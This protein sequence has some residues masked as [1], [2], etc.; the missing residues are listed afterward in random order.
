MSAPQDILRDRP[1]AA[2]ISPFDRL[3]HVR[4]VCCP[5]QSFERD[6]D[7]DVADIGSAGGVEYTIGHCKAC[8][9]L[10]VHCWV[11]GGISE[12]LEAVSQEFVSQLVSTSDYKSR[13]SLLKKWFDGLR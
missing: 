6:P 13:Q 9:G 4:M 10:L 7:P 8:G 11:G 5:N 12:G 1:R 3:Q 2:I